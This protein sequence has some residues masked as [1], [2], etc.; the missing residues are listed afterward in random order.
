MF[1]FR[2]SSQTLGIFFTHGWTNS[3][4]LISTCQEVWGF[5][6]VCLGK[7]SSGSWESR[8]KPPIQLASVFPSCSLL[9]ESGNLVSLLLTLVF[10]LT[11]WP[12]LHVFHKG[13]SL[14]LSAD[15][16]YSSCLLTGLITASSLGSI[17]PHVPTKDWLLWEL[18][19]GQPCSQYLW[20]SFGSEENLVRALS[21]LSWT[22]Y[23]CDLRKLTL[24]SQ[25]KDPWV[26]FCLLK[27]HLNRK[28]NMLK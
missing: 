20:T 24:K 19:W 21:P 13:I 8:V 23:A 5:F 18:G 1:T 10:S 22:S 14:V 25:I 16:C 15:L 9:E 12:V 2:Q 17:L 27:P 6:P 3:S 7:C 4:S 26:G 11:L 28:W